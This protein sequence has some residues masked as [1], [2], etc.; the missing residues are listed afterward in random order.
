MTKKS[1][2]IDA[3]TS[4]F[5]LSYPIFIELLAN[6]LISNIDSLML[7]HYSENSVAAVGNANQIL[8]ILVLTFGVIAT[9]TCVVVS[10]YL[11]ASKKDEM[12][13]IY[14]L[15]ISFNLVLGVIVSVILV[16]FSGVFFQLLNVSEEI[17]GETSL[18]I[19][20]V[21][22]F[23]F[24]QAVQ[25]V[26]VQILR[27]NGY[28]KIGMYIAVAANI[29]NIIGNYIFLYGPLKHL[30]L[31]V[32]GVAIS[33]VISRV[34][35]LLAA[36]LV[37]T[38]YSIGKISIRYLRPFPFYLLQK[39]IGVGLPSAGENFSYSLYQLVLLSFINKMG[40]EAVN[41]KVYA[42]LMMQF[43]IV[44][45][46]S[47][48]QATQ[49]IVGHLI[50]A[51]QEDAANKRLLSALKISLPVSIA[52][53]TINCLISP[54]TISLF[55]KNPDIIGL[56][57]KVLAVG[58]IMEIGRTT[59]IIIISSM[60]SSGDYLFPIFL[61][62]FSMWLIGVTVG[63]TFGTALGLGLVGTW[64]GTTADECFR[65]IVVYFRWKKGSWR[66]KQIVT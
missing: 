53:A 4:L 25:N 24:L 40:I 42:S 13:K 38:I 54:F 61:G 34:V 49:I 60:K 8:N 10:Q 21:G 28:T 11:G 7:S 58:I 29:L 39:M 43:S 22:G 31:G 46:H 2:K 15:S 3:N 32:A 35:A 33:T 57:T 48:G 63:Y 1:L 44:F 56:C 41:A 47:V 66:G 59:N 27:S 5:L 45:A 12:N 51:G 65:G 19:K 64:F 20:I 18:Y 62:L 36:I 55:T 17:I 30:N 23:L 52:I 16:L 26:F 14:T 9:A 37:F 6:I 50:G